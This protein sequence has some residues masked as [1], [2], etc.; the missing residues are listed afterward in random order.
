M[1]DEENLENKNDKEI[2]EVEEKK[3]QPK[4]EKNKNKIK[5]KKYDFKNEGILL[6]FNKIITEYS[7]NIKNRKINPKEEEKPKENEKKEEEQ[8]EGEPKPEEKKEEENKPEEKKEEDEEN[9]ARLELLKKE[10]ENTTFN[11]LLNKKEKNIIVSIIKDY[12]LY[13]VTRNEVLER[14]TNDLGSLCN[15]LEMFCEFQFEFLVLEKIKN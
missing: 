4:E 7:F 9:T 13:F 12:Y 5:I 8:K 11:E 3:L 2:N 15:L 10:L 1:E 6:I 14:E